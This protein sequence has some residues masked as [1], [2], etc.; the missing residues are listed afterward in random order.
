MHQ[1]DAGLQFLKPGGRAWLDA[2]VKK[3]EFVV[4]LGLP[5]GFALL[6]WPLCFVH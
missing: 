6:R 2:P 5:L 1:S 3:E 4:R